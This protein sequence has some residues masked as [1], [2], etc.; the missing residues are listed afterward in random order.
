[1]KWTFPNLRLF[2]SL[3]V[4]TGGIYPLAVTLISLIFF[5]HQAH[6][7]LIR[8]ERGEII[9]S[10][11][12]AQPFTSAKYFWPRPSAGGYATMPSAASNLSWT[13][14]KLVRVV[15][16]RK[17]ALLKAHNLPETTPVP[18]DM[19]FAS[20]SGL[21]PFISPEAAEFQLNRVAAARGVPLEKIRELVAEHFVRGGILGENVINVMTL[22][23]ALDT[24]FP[25]SGM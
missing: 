1:M 12:I 21:E 2:L 9:A 24:L 23:A 11:L 8:N 7:S 5:P 3:A 6:G 20:G 19:L 25:M 15:A 17:T 16:E 13:S 22:N 14:G 10:E 4:I 18:E